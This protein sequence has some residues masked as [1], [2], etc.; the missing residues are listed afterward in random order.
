MPPVRPGFTLPHLGAQADQPEA[1]AR[2][3]RL[4]EDLGADSLWDGDSVP[5]RSRPG[6]GYG[7]GST[8]P[9]EFRAVLNPLALLT[10]AARATRRDRLGSG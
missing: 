5:G 4:V 8:F 10:F 9:P 1:V 3:A 7:D 2:F 6:R